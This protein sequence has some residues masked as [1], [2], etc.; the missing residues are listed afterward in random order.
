MDKFYKA[1]KMIKTKLILITF[2]LCLFSAFSFGQL[3]IQLFDENFESVGGTF[4]LN[5]GGPVANFGTNKWEVN[6]YYIGMPFYPNTISENFTYSGSISFPDTPA[7]GTYLHIYDVNTNA[8]SNSNYNP[9]NGSDN[10][11]YMTTGVCTMG[12]NPINVTFFYN[13][14]GS[15]TAYGL[16]YYSVDGGPWIQ[17]G[18]P[19]YNLKTEWQ[20]E[21][22]TDPAFSNVQSLQIGFRWV[23]SA[24]SDTPTVSLGIDDVII[25]GTF[26]TTQYPLQMNITNVSPDTVC[27]GG[28]VF[29][30]YSMPDTLCD[31]TYLLQ[32]SDG[33]GNFGNL[34]NLFVFDIFYPQS[35]GTFGFL[36]PTNLG[37][38]PCY[39]LR[40]NRL[41]PPAFTGNAGPCITVI[42]CPNTIT[43]LQ[44][45]VTMDTNAV[46][47]GSVIDVP[48]YS[49]G[50]FTA[51]NVYTAVL[52]D[53]AG[54]F[55]SN[56]DTSVIGT[57]P[58]TKTYDPSLGS[59][60]GI[61]SGLVPDV[62]DGC[63]YYIH[64][65]SN[66]PPCVGSVW[67]PF[68]IQHCDINTNEHQSVHICLTPNTAS[69]ISPD[70]VL[71]VDVHSFYSDMVY[72]PGNI[73]KI[74]LLDMMAFQPVGALGALGQQAAT[75][76]TIVR[77]VIP[78]LNT[79]LA[80][81]I[82]PGAYYGRVVATNT[83]Y[84]D[85]ALGN[86]IHITIGA[87]SDIPPSTLLFDYST[88]TELTSDTICNTQTIFFE[89]NPFNSQSSYIWTSGQL[90][91]SPLNQQTLAVLFTGFQ[92]NFI[93]TLQEI[94]FGCPG[95]VSAP[96]TLYVMGPPNVAIT[97]PHYICLGDTGRYSVPFAP[98]TYYEWTSPNGVILDTANDSLN[99]K[100]DTVGSYTIH[101]L[102]VNQCGSAS[103]VKQIIVVNRPIAE[104]G[105]DTSIC[106]TDSIKLVQTPTN[107]AYGYKWYDGS[108]N[109]PVL[110]TADSVWVHPNGNTDYIVKVTQIQT[111]GVCYTLDTIHVNLLPYSLATHKDT[112]CVG[113]T[114]VLN[115]TN[116]GTS[117]HW[118]N[119]ATS[120]QISIY[121][122]G[123]FITI[124]PQSTGCPSIDSF[125][126][127]GIA[128]LHTSFTDTICYPD[129]VN[130]N[131]GSPGSSYHWST[132][133]TSQQITVN[134]GGTYVAHV[135]PS[136]ARCDN[137]DTFNIIHPMQIT[138]N[139]VDTICDGNEITIGLDSLISNATYLW[140]NG[141]TTSTITTNLG[142]IYILYITIPNSRCNN[143]DTFTV[144]DSLCPEM[145]LPNVFTPN[146][147]GKNDTWRPEIIG[148]Y[149]VFHVD[150]YNR[151]GEKI[152]QS[153]KTNFEW[154]GTTMSGSIVPD[155][156][157][158][159]IATGTRNSKIKHWHGYVTKI[160]NP[161]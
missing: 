1:N 35:S 132:G 62:P 94:N 135:T 93:W 17:T 44:P 76:D 152:W 42:A 114:L 112:I 156:T 77:I 91:N 75:S 48:F 20:Y 140:S 29:F 99:I 64:V 8:V 98:N 47:V 157:Y 87:P 122:G 83:N 128:R 138:G 66:H 82:A 141:A 125:Y 69:Y 73:F 41:S 9:A 19:Q 113:D 121:T 3:S 130:L 28:Q 11:A 25:E 4:T 30:D 2:V 27:V 18:N 92:G 51:G 143:L 74:Q 46:C 22:I 37:P 154:P 111:L 59:L 16:V 49:T 101:I 40:I 67:G 129:T 107:A 58:D 106:L 31:G 95:P 119:G 50:Q 147:D 153:D 150:I 32:I 71:D 148:V 149:D 158:Y 13:G 118:N 34:T 137:L 24:T 97:G 86:L 45:V 70:S 145:V 68:C 56:S 134:A 123:T 117:Y 151:W 21:T 54:N 104:A 26:D 23:N 15:A 90:Q 61:V 55:F 159:Y 109:N 105:S 120:Q 65:I 53:S 12:M 79:L 88:F 116:T 146:G 110:G 5:S 133:S 14:T 89:P 52:S 144:S 78:N 7:H 43:T 124:I 72:N 84:P 81:G 39:R 57:D 160:T 126:V 115:P 161:K 127:D 96:D 36:M 102:A 142:G 80:W 139:I 33:N 136:G 131:A 103:G 6:N 60:P 108:I 85:S 38:G 63:H 10:F 155:G 100:F